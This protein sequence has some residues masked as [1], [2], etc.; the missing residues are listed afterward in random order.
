VT[1]TP[2]WF[3]DV[4]R[5]PWHGIPHVCPELNPERL[6]EAHLVI[7]PVVG[8]GVPGVLSEHLLDRMPG[9]SRTK[10]NVIAATPIKDEQWR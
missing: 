3:T 7:D 10:K 1:G 8:S 9:A 2:S 5:S 4:P 6:V